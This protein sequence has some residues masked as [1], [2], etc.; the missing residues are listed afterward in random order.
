MNAGN[1]S[2][3]IAYLKAY[4]VPGNPVTPINPPAQ[5]ETAPGSALTLFHAEELPNGVGISYVVR[6]DFGGGY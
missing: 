1:P 5:V 6:G 2:L 3:F 4:H